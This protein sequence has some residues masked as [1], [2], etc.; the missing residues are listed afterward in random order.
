V[1]KT[2]TVSTEHLTFA[3]IE[4]LWIQVGGAPAYAATMAGIAE[5]ESGGW[6]GAVAGSS[7][8]AAAKTSTDGYGGSY[9]LWQIN[10]SHAGITDST[11]PSQGGATPP[12]AWV[13]NMENPLYNAQWAVYLLGNGSGMS[14][15]TNDPVG[16]AAL[17]AG[18]SLDLADVLSAL[19]SSRANSLDLTGA[20]N[21]NGKTQNQLDAFITGILGKT[22]PGWNAQISPLIAFW[23]SPTPYFGSGAS[24]QGGVNSDSGIPGGGVLHD[25]ETGVDSVG[26]LIKDLTSGELWIRVGEYLLGFLLV[27]AGGILFF[28][29]TA[30]GQKI[31]GGAASAASVA[32]L[33]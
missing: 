12:A 29:S 11:P 15:W 31:E 19:G 1:S 16:N 14:A 4:A 25:I 6:V 28:K 9:G 5:A 27:V 20:A 32:A 26:G 22:A 8:G 24:A 21:L 13:A 18:G 10:G 7:P 23:N 33:G 30:T 17:A 2:P 3:Q